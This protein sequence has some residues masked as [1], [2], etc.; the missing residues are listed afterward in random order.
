VQQRCH[1]RDPAA[2]ADEEDAGDAG[3]GQLRRRDRRPRRV[4][5]G[6]QDRAGQLLELVAAERRVLVGQRDVDHRGRRPGQHLLGGPHVLPQQAV[7]AALRGRGRPAQ[8]P[9]Q[10]GVAGRVHRA[11][12]ADDRRVDVQTAALR[13]PL[14]REH[15]E[16]AALDAAHHRGVEGARARVVDHEGAA[17]PHGGGAEVDEHAR[18]RHRLGHQRDRSQPGPLGGGHQDAAPGLRPRGRVGHRRRPDIAPGHPA[19][20][21]RDPPEHG[22][23]QVDDADLAVAEQHP[24]LVDAPLRVRFEP[25]RA[26]PGGVHGVA[27]DQQ[28]AAGV[29]V[30]GRRQR[31][32][33]VEEKGSDLPAGP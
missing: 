9:P 8:P 17:G 33:P 13:E 14:G 20:L 11:Q 3:R 26:H 16:A 18:R 25:L 1:Q 23:D 12:V 7:G 24:G 15:L 31:R 28:T 6:V 2:A 30:D 27:A 19:R 5:G 4:H 29:G 21:G 32:R 10:L 22:R